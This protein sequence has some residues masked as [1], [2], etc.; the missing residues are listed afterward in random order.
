MAISATAGATMEVKCNFIANTVADIEFG[1]FFVFESARDHKRRLCFK[2]YFTD[3]FKDVHALVV[4]LV[5]GPIEGQPSV[6]N[7]NDSL[8]APALELKNVQISI[9]NNTD[10][11]QLAPSDPVFGS[12]VVRAEDTFLVALAGDNSTHYFNLRTGAALATLRSSAGITA[13]Q[14]SIVVPGIEGPE[15]LYSFERSSGVKGHK[16]HKRPGK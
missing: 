4:E 10:A 14:W 6:I 11:I 12:I 5:P 16:G 8:T 7:V 9:A 13:L 2:G 15:V 1:K 3:Q